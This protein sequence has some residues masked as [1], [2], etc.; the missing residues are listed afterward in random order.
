MLKHFSRVNLEDLDFEEVDKEMEADKAVQAV[1]A[2]LEEN[3]PEGNDREPEDA[4]IDNAGGDEAT[5]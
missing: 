2:T 4:S 1:A 5:V 3:A